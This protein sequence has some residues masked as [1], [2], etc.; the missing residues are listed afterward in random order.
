MDF[1]FLAQT[2]HSTADTVARYFRDQ[3]G[4]THI[5]AEIEVESDIAYR[6]TLLGKTQDHY[7]LCVEVTDVGFSGALKD[8]VLAC[9][10]RSLPVKC[11]MAIP[12]GVDDATFREIRRRT[13]EHGVGLVEAESNGCTMIHPAMPLSLYGVRKIDTKRF[14][15]RYRQA[16]S[17]AET[18]FRS[19]DP[20]KGCSRVY[21]EIERLTR[22]I[23]KKVQGKGLWR[24]THVGERRASPNLDTG[25]WRKVMD[26]LHGHLDYKRL[27]PQGG[28]LNTTLLGKVLGIVPHRNDTGHK[29]VSKAALIARDRQLRTRFEHAVD[30][31]DELVRASKVLKI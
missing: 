8:F 16:L 14:P 31:F 21:D 24:P 10:A 27:R 29:P 17:D 12:K 19:G 3:H 2:L 18:V 25:S 9:S 22:E 26:L 28:A 1:N 5:K 13:Q 4:V 15:P 30:T 7:L 20:A 11:F 23:A 6:P